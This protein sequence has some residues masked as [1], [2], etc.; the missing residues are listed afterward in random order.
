MM[1]PGQLHL[2]TGFERPPEATERRPDGIIEVADVDGVIY[3]ALADTP[4]NPLIMHGWYYGYPA[5]CVR[6]FAYSWAH[7]PRDGFAPWP[8]HPVS[9]HL[10][11]PECQAGELA[12]LPD[13]PA[14]RYGWASWD[15]DEGPLF[16]P[17]SDY[18]P[19]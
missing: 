15:P 9:G 12:P 5:C 11:C 10:L 8:K 7:R 18:D 2:F 16:Y 19:T 17:P 3:L 13:R 4:D 6:W 14:R 1:I